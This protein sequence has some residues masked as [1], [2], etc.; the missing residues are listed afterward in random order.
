LSRQ[1]PTDADD[2]RGEYGIGPEP[3]PNPRWR[4]PVRV[5]VSALEYEPAEEKRDSRS[6]DIPLPVQFLLGVLSVMACVAIFLLPFGICFVW[7]VIP[8]Y[9]ATAR[10]VRDNVGWRGFV[11]GVICG[12]LLLPIAGLAL[13]GIIIGSSGFH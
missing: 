7:L 12:V 9:L 11:P 1:P 8:G 5:R 13:C 6:W 10:A 2:D 3:T 4:P